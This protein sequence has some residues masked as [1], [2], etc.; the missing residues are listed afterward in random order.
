MEG[1]QYYTPDNPPPPP[2]SFR[3][4]VLKHKGSTLNGSGGFGDILST[5]SIN[6]RIPRRLPSSR[7]QESELVQCPKACFGRGFT[8]FFLG[9]LI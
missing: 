1:V 5:L 2:V 4:D 8:F 9:L 6:K 7:S 3:V